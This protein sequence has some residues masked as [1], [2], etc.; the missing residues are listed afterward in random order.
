MVYDTLTFVGYVMLN[1][2]STF[3]YQ[4]YMNILLVTL[5]L[6]ESQLICLH[7]V[8]RFQELLS[9]TRS[10]I[11]TQLYGFKNCYLTLIILFNIDNNPL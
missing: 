9:N 6:N 7:T 10:T 3:V 2:V 5:L 4:I 11:C 8:K 1:P